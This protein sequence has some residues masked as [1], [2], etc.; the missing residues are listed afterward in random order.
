MVQHSFSL[1]S[2]QAS[3]LF[4]HCLGLC[5]PTT[6]TSSCGIC[7]PPPATICSALQLLLPGRALFKLPVLTTAAL[8]LLLQDHASAAAT[9]GWVAV[10]ICCRI[11]SCL[12]VALCNLSVSGAAMVCRRSASSTTSSLHQTILCRTRVAAV[13]NCIC[14]VRVPVAC[15]LPPAAASPAQRLLCLIASTLSPSRQTKQLKIG[16]TFR[17]SEAR[18]GLWHR[19]C[20]QHNE[21]GNLRHIGELSL[22]C[23]GT[24]YGRANL[25]KTSLCNLVYTMAA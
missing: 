3:D 15:R 9:P 13:G 7:S 21:I 22:W 10:T 8:E 11:C 16:F 6:K 5:E 23:T 4:V 25:T 14:N 1:G 20:L 18:H 2:A 17:C 19:N 12:P 24:V